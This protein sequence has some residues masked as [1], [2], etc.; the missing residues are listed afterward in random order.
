MPPDELPEPLP[1]ELPEPLPEPEPLPD[2]LP[3]LLPDED[4]P[5][6][7][8]DEDTVPHAFTAAIWHAARSFE[9]QDAQVNCW[10]PICQ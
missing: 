2:E 3:E 7:P 5:S 10:P 8:L 6:P 9:S 1:E 4:P